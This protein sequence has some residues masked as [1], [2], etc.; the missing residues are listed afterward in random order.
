MTRQRHRDTG[1]DEGKSDRA[2][3][4][5]YRGSLLRRKC[6]RSPEPHYLWKG[7]V[8]GLQSASGLLDQFDY[9]IINQNHEGAGD[10]FLSML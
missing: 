3:S 5:T 7:G 9:R 6:P 4:L 8:E 2:T 10:N 1:L